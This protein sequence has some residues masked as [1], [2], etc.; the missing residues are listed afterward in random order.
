MS[1][2]KKRKNLDFGILYVI[3]SVFQEWSDFNKNGTIEESM[4]N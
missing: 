2:S 3:F 4:G 1:S